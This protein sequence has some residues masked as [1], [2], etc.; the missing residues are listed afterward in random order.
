MYIVDGIAYAGEQTKL[1]NVKSVQPI[2]D[3][4]VIVTFSNEEKKK[5]DFSALLNMPCYQPLKDKDIFKSVSVE[6]GT[7]VWNN[8][9]IDIAPE[10]LYEKG[11][12]I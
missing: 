8:G 5:F 3:Y 1:I 2:E 10:T 7:L 12:A 6:F 4:K 9:E 11:I